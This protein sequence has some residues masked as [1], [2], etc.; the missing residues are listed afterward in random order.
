MPQSI[1]AT[2]A[3]VLGLLSIVLG[4]CFVIGLLLGIIGLVRSRAGLREL[5][6]HPSLGGLG[7]LKAARFCSIIGIVLGL[8]QA[9]LWS[10]YVIV[11]L[12]TTVA[13]PASAGVTS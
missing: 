10:V 2:P 5:A 3:L 1:H 11:Y 12:G 9:V 7:L 13:D 8:V 6:V 4:A